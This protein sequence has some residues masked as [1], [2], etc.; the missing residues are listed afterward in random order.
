MR[1]IRYIWRQL[2]KQDQRPLITLK[3]LITKPHWTVRGL[4]PRFQKNQTEL[5]GSRV[6]SLASRLRMQTAHV[7]RA[8]SQSPEKSASTHTHKG[9]QMGGT[10]VAQ[11]V[12][13]PTRC[14]KIDGITHLQVLLRVSAPPKLRNILLNKAFTSQCIL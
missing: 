13:G 5:D 11:P 7:R 3:S 12:L 9:V 6:K 4:K 10:N 1:K 8:T 2:S 14:S